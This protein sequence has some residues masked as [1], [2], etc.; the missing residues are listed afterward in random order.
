MNLQEIMT[1]GRGSP[2]S[3][4]TAGPLGIAP[5]NHR[6]CRHCSENRF[7]LGLGFAFSAV[8][9]M[10]IWEKL[11]LTFCTEY[12]INI[13]FYLFACFFSLLQSL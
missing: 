13:K 7:I 9:F 8:L 11:F 4:K 10:S 12:E 6:A 2:K 1:I 3:W 5:L